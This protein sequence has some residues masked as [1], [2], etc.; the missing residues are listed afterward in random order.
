MPGESL[1][2]AEE[3]KKKNT[4]EFTFFIPSLYSPLTVSR[5]PEKVKFFQALSALIFVLNET[6][7]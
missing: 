6:R 4:L 7:T 5:R 1:L 3:K 2:A